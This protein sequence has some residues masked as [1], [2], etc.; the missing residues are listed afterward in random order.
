MNS[1][2]S[3]SFHDR[4]FLSKTAQSFMKKKVS[5]KGSKMN[6]ERGEFDVEEKESV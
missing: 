3:S 5:K 6:S 2:K 1:K 4:S